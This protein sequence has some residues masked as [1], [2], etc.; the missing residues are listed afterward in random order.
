MI[1]GRNSYKYVVVGFNGD[2][3]STGFA[4]RVRAVTAEMTMDGSRAL[5][6]RFVPLPHRGRSWKPTFPRNGQVDLLEIP[7]LPI[8][9]YAGL[10]KV[11]VKISGR[12][13]R[14]IVG[15]V[16]PEVVQ[17]ECH[18]AAAIGGQLDFPG[19]LYADLHGA[20]PEEA[21][22][23]RQA[24]GRTDLSIVDWLNRIESAIVRRFDKL[25]V[26]APRMIEHLETKTGFAVSDK[27][28]VLPVFADEKFFRPLHKDRIKKE[29]GLEGKTVFLYSGG[30]QRYQC[31]DQTIHWFRELTARV[32]N[33]AFLI[34][35]PGPEIAAQRVQDLLGHIP[36]NVRIESVAR[37]NLPDYISA[38]DFGFVLRE[39]EVLNAV[40]SPTKAVEYLAR[41]V[42]LICTE[43]A[44]S[45]VDY[46]KRFGAGM[47]VPLVPDAVDVDR[48]VANID[49][50]M[51]MEVPVEAVHAELSRGGYA[52]A[53]RQLY[54]PE[55]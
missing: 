23:A 50:L 30:L 34:Y 54:C 24:D 18:E 12:I 40:A 47:L 14:A 55:T 41:G 20:A 2:T 13:L 15:R 29:L 37:D 36:G 5:V 31:I 44:G 7:S 43:H 28:V 38:A 6:V 16:R 1:P 39:P 11:S 3:S 53:L 45:A 10:R 4:S 52:N 46:V 42:R 51:T 49:C 32:P 17:C 27:T 8:S 26:V 9:R 19:L 33:A 48:A 22:Y 21:L 25:I 35:T